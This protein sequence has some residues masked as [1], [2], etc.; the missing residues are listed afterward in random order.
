MQ[1]SLLAEVIGK[2]Q[3]QPDRIA[4]QYGFGTEP[5]TMPLLSARIRLPGFPG[6]GASSEAYTENNQD[7]L[8]NRNRILGADKWSKGVN[9]L[10]CIPGII[11]SSSVIFSPDRPSGFVQ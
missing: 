10:L 9:E 5:E 8:L 6:P 2:S 11:I 7:L 4:C 1:H 3:V